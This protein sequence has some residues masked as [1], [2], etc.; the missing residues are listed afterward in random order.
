MYPTSLEAEAILYGSLPMAEKVSMPKP[1]DQGLTA[2][3]QTLINLL[4]QEI[5]LHPLRATCLL[6]GLK[7]SRPDAEAQQATM[8]LL[9]SLRDKQLAERRIACKRWC[10]RLTEAGRELV[11]A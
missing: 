4:D 6:H 2:G 8:S 10:W 11:L 7:T 1:V 5:V 3:E 9:H